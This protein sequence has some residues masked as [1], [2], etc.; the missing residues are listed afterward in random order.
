VSV[1]PPGALAL[2]LRPASAPAGVPD[3]RSPLLGEASAAE[4]FRLADPAL[5]HVSVRDLGITRGDGVFEGI[6]AVRG[7]PQALDAHLRRLASSAAAL[8][9]PEPD[10]D[11]WRAAILAVCA[12]LAAHPQIAVKAV[13]TRGVEGAGVPTGWVHGLPATDFR[14]LRISGIAVV[15]LDRG[16]RHDVAQ[17]SPWLL[18]GAKTLSYAVNTAAMREA[19]RRGADDVVFVSSDGIVLEGPTSS[20]LLRRG[21]ALL[22][23]GTGLAILEGTTQGTVFDFARGRGLRTGFELSTVADLHSADAAWLLSSVR[24]AVPITA[25]DGIP[26]GVDRTLTDEI[27]VHLAQVAE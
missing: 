26:K 27:N 6:S 5:P 4:T 22:T 18:Q 9:L 15:T 2:M 25:I 7:R 10:L 16:Y 8:D 1:A 11:A 20:V 19:K 24:H 3:T 12:A 21:N 13:Y 14:G 23:P 17:T